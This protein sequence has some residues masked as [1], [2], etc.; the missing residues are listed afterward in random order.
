MNL[1]FYSALERLPLGITVALEFTGPLAVALWHSRRAMDFLWV[2]LA[3][4]GLVLIVPWQGD[5]AHAIDPLGIVLALCAGLFWGLY[6]VWGREAGLVAGTRT[7]A[8]G[9]VIGAL[10]V[11]PFRRGRGVACTRC[12]VVARHR[13]QRGGAVERRPLYLRDAGD[14]AH[15][16]ARI[17]CVDE[18]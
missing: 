1:S 4:L 10:V 8:L 3:V 13:H 6:I 18:P 12:A 15:A 11:A 16:G 9:M 17:R 14:D 7:V 2:G 5:P